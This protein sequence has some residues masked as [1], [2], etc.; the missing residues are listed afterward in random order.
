MRMKEV[1]V[2]FLYAFIEER[3]HMDLPSLYSP[4]TVNTPGVVCAHAPFLYVTA[5]ISLRDDGQ[6]QSFEPTVFI[7]P[8]KG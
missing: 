5:V 7:S 8:I 1:G 3:L 4:H 6:E 2:F